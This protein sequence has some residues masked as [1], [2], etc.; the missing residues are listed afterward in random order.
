MSDEIVERLRHTCMELRNANADL[1]DENAHHHTKYAHLLKQYADMCD[2]NAAMQRSLGE[3]DKIIV[4]LGL[5]DVPELMR[6]HEMVTRM[7]TESQAQVSALA[8]HVR[9]LVKQVSVRD[10]FLK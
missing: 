8:E 1:L 10:G 9:L 3:K 2:A 6:R 5:V 4:D 7:Y